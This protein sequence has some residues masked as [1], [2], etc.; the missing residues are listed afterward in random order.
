MFR[1]IFT[2]IRIVFWMVRQDSLRK[3][4]IKLN[5]AGKIRERDELVFGIVPKWAQYVAKVTGTTVTVKG[6]EKIPQDRA[7]VIIANHQGLMDIPAIY[8]YIPKAISFIS[9]VEIKKIPLIRDWMELL[10]CTFMNR[11]SPKDSVKAIYDAAEGVKKGYS[12]VIFPEG[13]RSK[14]GPH[15]QFKPGSFKLAFLS[16]APILPVTISGT[17]KVYE[18]HKKIKKGNEVILTVHEP[19]E[20]AGL[21]REQQALIPQQVENTVCSALIQP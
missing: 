13:T 9:K 12:Q 21:S 4:A 10:Q 3:Q 18:E 19:V 2:L 17:Y 8:G 11:K 20:T 15:R 7:V 1:N 6:L 16:Q 5:K 14:G